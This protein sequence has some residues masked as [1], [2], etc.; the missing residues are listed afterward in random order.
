M[1]AN[2]ELLLI[3][4]IEHRDGVANAAEILSVPGIDGYFIGPGDLC[5]SLGLPHTWDP[6]FPEYWSALERV[7]RAA[8]SAGVPGGIHT[9]AARVSKM[10]GLGYQF[11]A[12]GF[13]ISFMAQG[14]TAALEAA[15]AKG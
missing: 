11:I 2:E 7:R 8:A 4:E 12:L 9:S 15:R 3:A 1:H 14:A 13:D 6:D 5:A 10:L